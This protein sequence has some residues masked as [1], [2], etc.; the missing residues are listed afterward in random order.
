VPSLT[1]AA[2]RAVSQWKFQ[3]ALHNGKPTGGITL[4]VISFLRPVLS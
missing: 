4:A 1:E 2:R 3:P